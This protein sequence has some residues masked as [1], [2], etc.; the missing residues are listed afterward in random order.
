[1][2]CIFIDNI[3][4]RII[5]LEMSK[6]TDLRETLVKNFTCKDTNPAKN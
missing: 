5:I 4:R 6:E 3:L 2:I 1:M